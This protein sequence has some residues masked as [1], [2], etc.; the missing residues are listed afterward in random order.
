LRRNIRKRARF[1]GILLF[2][3]GIVGLSKAKAIWN[4]PNGDYEY[5]NGTIIDILY[6]CKPWTGRSGF[7]S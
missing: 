3:Y 4:L 1:T 6:I 2:G 5:F 7:K